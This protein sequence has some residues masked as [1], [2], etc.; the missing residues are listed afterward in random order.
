MKRWRVILFFVLAATFT[1]VPTFAQEAYRTAPADVPRMVIHTATDEASD[2]YIFLASAFSRFPNYLLIFAPDGE[3]VY[4]QPTDGN[5]IDFKPQPAGALTWFTQNDHTHTIT[6][7][8]YTPIGTFPPVGSYEASGHDLNI[9][10]DGRM[11]RTIFEHDVPFDLSGLGGA[12]DAIIIDCVIHEQDA[13]GNTTFEFRTSEHL[14]PDNLVTDPQNPDSAENS[15]YHCNSVKYTADGNIII[16]Y[17]HRNQIV[18]VDYETG[19]VMWKFGGLNSDFT[20][21]NGDSFT[22][23]HDAQEHPNDIITLFDNRSNLT[24]EYSRGVRYQL[25]FE[26]MTA[27]TIWEY[28]HPQDI[29]SNFIGN[30][31]TLSNG[32][33]LINWGF[34]S[35]TGDIMATELT[36]DN[37]IAFE[38]GLDVGAASYRVL[39]APW[40][41]NPAEP[42][43]LDVVPRGDEVTFYM[44]WNGGT[45]HHTYRIYEGEVGVYENRLPGGDVARDGFETVAT[46]SAPPRDGD[47]YYRI[48][49]LDAGGNLLNSSLPKT[50]YIGD[51]FV[52]LPTI[53]YTP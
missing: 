29:Y 44:S 50:V 5:A 16:S 51:K 17:R 38:F 9:T 15:P 3:M 6:D 18:K 1:A 36:P 24:P 34:A 22:Y 11:L 39:R 28:R 42:P 40:I 46:F 10:E 31:Q 2:D 49:T 4:Y 33:S 37:D 53:L 52:F 14:A 12:A 43:A 47:Y 35:T 25:D 19:E 41:G 8:T 21:A 45:E 27:E 26:T 20:F 30:L 7:N 32:N 48:E 13:D 23:Q